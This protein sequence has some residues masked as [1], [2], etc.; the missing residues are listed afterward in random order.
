M[1]G[2]EPTGERMAIRSAYG[3]KLKALKLNEAVD[4]FTKL[5]NAR[6]D[7]LRQAKD[8]GTPAPTPTPT[9]APAPADDT[10][11]AIET[12]ESADAVPSD[13]F[14]DDLINIFEDEPESRPEADTVF[15]PD[16]EPEITPEASTPEV[17]IEIEEIYE[18]SGPE[19]LPEE[20]PLEEDVYEEDVY[21]WDDN[22]AETSPNIWKTPIAIF[23][24]IFIAGKIFNAVT[25]SSDDAERPVPPPI[26]Q[27]PKITVAER[28][29]PPQVVSFDEGN[30][31]IGQKES[32]LIELFGSAQDADQD[33]LTSGDGAF[34]RAA[35][36]YTAF[37]YSDQQMS[38]TNENL[39]QALRARVQI[40]AE[41]ANYDQLLAIKQIKLEMMQLSR[42]VAGV[43][44]CAEA[45]RTGRLPSD[46]QVPEA[47]RQKERAIA[48]SLLDAGLLGER[49]EQDNQ[50]ST[51]N[52]L[53]PQAVRQEVLRKSGLQDDE[54]ARVA[55]GE[56]TNTAQC[57]FR[58][59]LA[60][61]VLLRPGEIDI[62][63]LRIL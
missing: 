52:P 60:E 35:R 20:E 56:G 12:S 11:E 18:L 4:S 13:D 47:L 33:L 24:V 9:P 10:S 23:L 28:P 40:A 32:L 26:S 1:L 57:A 17:E 21:D 49:S 45:A 48:R 42:E 37:P 63:L 16:S 41:K 39:A 27:A 25:G 43:Y 46:T 61:A 34:W 31:T 53:I 51:A 15:S 8:I 58:I 2:I 30:W 44:D 54:A 22:S 55:S 38:S 6:D 3:R 62:D 19:E 7:A 59:A 36:S 5:R 50:N 14:P 29:P